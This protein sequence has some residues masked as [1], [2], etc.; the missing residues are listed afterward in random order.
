MRDRGVI[1][2]GAIKKAFVHSRKLAELDVQD[3]DDGRLALESPVVVANNG[4]TTA[5]LLHTL[6]DE[7]NALNNIQG[8]IL[9]VA[10]SKRLLTGREVSLVVVAVV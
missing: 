7:A 1:V 6:Y 8:R 10:R 5:R 9:A 2:S 4:A 3:A